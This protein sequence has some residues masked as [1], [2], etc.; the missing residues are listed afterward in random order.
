MPQNQRSDLGNTD[1]QPNVKAASKHDWFKKPERPPTLDSE[2][3]DRKTIDFRRPQTWISRIAHAEK[4]PLTFD[5]LISTPID[6]SA[7][8]MN[9]LKIDNLT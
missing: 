9:N 6:L 1:D 4:P 5:E 3:N 2:W 7:Y 8:V